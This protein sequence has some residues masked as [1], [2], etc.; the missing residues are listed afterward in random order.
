MAS[1][2]H[3]YSS[4]ILLDGWKRYVLAFLCGSVASFAQPPYGWFGL[5]WLCLPVLIALLDSA[6]LGHATASAAKRM[7]ATGWT[8][9][10]GFFLATFYWLGAAFLVEAEKFAWAMPLAIVILP[11][12]LSLFWAFAMAALAPVWT[13]HWTRILWLSLFLSAIEWLRGFILTGLPWGG[14]GFALSAHDWTLQALSLLGPD[15]MTLWALLLFTLPIVWVSLEAR[16]KGANLYAMLAL[17]LF[18]LQLFYGFQR[19]QQDPQKPTEN[20]TAPV[21]RLVQPNIPQTEK[22]KL[23]NRSWIFNRL[24]AMTSQSSEQAPAQE[25]DLVIWPESAIPFY[26]M[27]QPAALA[28]LANALPGQSQLMTGAL[29][30]QNLADGR[31]AVFNSIYW[32]GADG[33]VLGAYDKTHLVPF[34]E[35]LPFQA[36]L[37]TIG[38]EQLTRLK[39]GF[40]QGR[41]RNLFQTSD[42]GSVLP[43]ICYEIAFSNEVADY[44]SRPDWILTLTN[45]A[46]FGLSIGPQQHLFMARMRAVELGL[47]VIRVANTGISAI[48]DHKGRIL[49]YLSLQKTGIIQRSLPGET[50]QTLFSQLKNTAFVGIWFFLMLILVFLRRKV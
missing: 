14:F 31:D 23:E 8:F 42:L 16:D 30:R 5:L 37:E 17:V 50:S 45:D 24:I 11:A 3:F 27:E 25:V 46:W 36:L 28:A 21:I 12:G 47:P 32:L 35:Y 6:S 34:G 39:G 41:R 22:W 19:L 33:A 15:L 2:R 4:L 38:L 48:I 10:F 40:T 1:V 13:D 26:L 7:F 43:L 29:R 20:Q 9:A 44:K 49:E 18:A